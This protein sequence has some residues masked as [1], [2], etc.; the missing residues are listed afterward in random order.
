ML[1]G[2][3]YSAGVL[4]YR[5]G[6]QRGD[7]VRRLDNEEGCRAQLHDSLIHHGTGI[8]V[9]IR[10]LGFSVSDRLDTKRR[11]SCTAASSLHSPWHWNG[12][13]MRVFFFFFFFRAWSFASSPSRI[14]TSQHGERAERGVFSSFF[15]SSFVGSLLIGGPSRGFNLGSQCNN[16][17]F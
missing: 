1:L 11:T 7:F 6:R 14:G 16:S 10:R 8:G 3:G 13:C 17:I 12:V 9:C 2:Y 15:C 5:I 4:R